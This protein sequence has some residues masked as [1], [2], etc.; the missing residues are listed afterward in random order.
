MFHLLPLNSWYRTLSNERTRLMNRI[1]RDLRTRQMA[2]KRWWK[3]LFNLI[4]LERLRVCYQNFVEIKWWWMMADYSQPFRFLPGWPGSCVHRFV[5]QFQTYRLYF[6]IIFKKNTFQWWILDFPRR[7]C[8]P[9][10]EASRYNFIKFS[11]KNAWNREKFGR[12][13]PLHFT[14]S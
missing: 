6:H 5:F 12:Y 3:G 4:Q 11:P 2:P 14:R 13:P 10:G 9:S 1:G 7:G 8:Q